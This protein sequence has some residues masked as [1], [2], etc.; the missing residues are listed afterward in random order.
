MPINRLI[1]KYRAVKT[2]RIYE[3]DIDRQEKNRR[4]FLDLEERNRKCGPID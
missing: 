3:G 1:V 2:F 4:K